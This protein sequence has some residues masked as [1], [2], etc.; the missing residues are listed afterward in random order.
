MAQR[1]FKRLR[2]RMETPL[3]SP[4]NGPHKS[5]GKINNLLVLNGKGN[6]K[7]YL[8][9]GF[10]GLIC[11]SMMALAKQRGIEVCHSSQKTESQEGES[12]LPEGFHANGDCYPEQECI[13]HRLMGS[14][15]KPSILKFEPVIIVYKKAS[16]K[17]DGAHKVQIA[18]NNH[19]VL[20]YKTKKAIQDYGEK[21]FSG[22]F[23][24]VIELLEKLS[25]EEL[26]FLIEAILYSPEL[27][28]GA[29]INNGSGRLKIH[30]VNYQ[31]VIRTR[32]I[33]NKGKIVEEEKV[34]NLWKELEEIMND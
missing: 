27:G 24:L 16:G 25:K 15:K 28:L 17:Q 30:E 33:G 14:I 8:V 13:K 10:R 3:A 23:E 21:F 1:T 34:R 22:E 5:G 26:H 6:D 29:K 32:T 9:K 4:A 19:N 20:V 18:T 12:F 7:R 11:H 2:I 31:K